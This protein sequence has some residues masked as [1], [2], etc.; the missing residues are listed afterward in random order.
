MRYVVN[1]RPL[2]SGGHGD[3]FI[4]QLSDTGEQVVVKFLREYHIAQD[5]KGFIREV[6][7]L[8]RRRHGLIPLLFAN[9]DAERPYYVMP[10]LK[11]G[12]LTQYA[13]TLTRSHLQNIATQLAATLANLHA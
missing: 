10:Y 13:G 7:I 11:G 3:L 4:G 9:T 2:R 1:L 6:R 12:A 5:R 8:E